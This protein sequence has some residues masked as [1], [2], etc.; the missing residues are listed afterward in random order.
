MGNCNCVNYENNQYQIVVSK[1]DNNSDSKNRVNNQLSP[2]ITSRS[3][4]IFTKSVNSY[5][6]CATSTRNN[7]SESDSDFIESKCLSA[8]KIQKLYRNYKK[9][10]LKS[11][12]NNNFEHD[13]NERNDA[14]LSS[15]AKHSN[16]DNSSKQ[17]IQVEYNDNNNKVYK[18]SKTVSVLKGDQD[19]LELKILDSYI[20]PNKLPD[21]NQI[22]KISENKFYKGEWTL[23]ELNHLERNGFG[24]LKFG[25]NIFTGYFCNDK[26]NKFGLFTSNEG[27]TYTGNYYN[28]KM[29]GYGI[30][31]NKT[32]GTVYQGEFK[33]DKQS[34]YGIEI[35]VNGSSYEGNFHNNFKHEIGLLKFDDSSC[36]KGEFKENDIQGIGTFFFSNGNKY[37]GQWSK[38]KMQGIGVYSFADGSV[39]EGEFNN[40]V[41]EGFGVLYTKGK[42]KVFMG[43][44]KNN[45]MDGE[46]IIVK[47]SI[48]RKYIFNNSKKVNELPDNYKLSFN[49]NKTLKDL[50]V[51]A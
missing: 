32:S 30:Y 4:R 14:Y 15:I 35:W 37:E 9:V 42:K 2:L 44:W 25:E 3:N 48:V 34:N 21:K 49:Y 7:K 46:G 13:N 20:K 28:D 36:F 12:N 17:L 26:A 11:L 45:K 1:Q 50:G 33:D 41:K 40:D 38:N 43:F 8:L 31:C 18:H 6:T 47:D 29:Q 16:E 23:N 5:N 19:Y 39:F 51:K 27:D 24:T 22:V 10:N